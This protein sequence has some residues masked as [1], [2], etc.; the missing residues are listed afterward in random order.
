MKTFNHFLKGSGLL[1]KVFFMLLVFIIGCTKDEIE[2]VGYKDNLNEMNCKN[3]VIPNQTILLQG[4]T[5]FA[6]Y[7][8]KEGRY[9]TDGYTMNF[10]ICTA[11]LIFAGKQNFV[12]NTKEYMPLP[13][14]PALYRELSFNGKMTPSGELK[15]T[16]PETWIELGVV[17]SDVFEQF[18]EHTGCVLSKGNKQKL[19]EYHGYFVGNKFFAENHAVAFQKAPGNLPF[20]AV[21]VDGPIKINF[22]IDLEVTD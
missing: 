21:V 12:L 4:F 16:W 13:D 6:F 9:I 8:Q 1:M 15:F 22:M 11:E 18:T 10:L 3:V 20:F 7:A 2:R 5:R 19:L 14:G 17:R